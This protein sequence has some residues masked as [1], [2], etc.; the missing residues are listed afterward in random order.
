MAPRSAAVGN[1]WKNAQAPAAPAMASR[2]VGHARHVPARHEGDQRAGRDAVPPTRSKERALTLPESRR[3]H[4]LDG[5]QLVLGPSPNL[6]A[7]AIAPPGIT[8]EERY[9]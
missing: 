1:T 5:Q 2:P 3:L 9:R 4:T 8:H 7:L 6:H